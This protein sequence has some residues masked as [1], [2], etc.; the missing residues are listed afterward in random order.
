MK[1]QLEQKEIEFAR[2][3]RLP[4]PETLTVGEMI[5]LVTVVDRSSGVLGIHPV[6]FIQWSRRTDVL[7]KSLAFQEFMEW[8]DLDFHR[9]THI[10]AAHEFLA[11]LVD[12]LRKPSK[13]IRPMLLS[14]AVQ[15]I[16]Q[17]KDAPAVISEHHSGRVESM[18]RQKTDSRVDL[19]PIISA[20]RDVR[21]TLRHHAELVSAP[22][23]DVT[24]GLHR[25]SLAIGNAG[26]LFPTRNEDSEAVDFCNVVSTCM[27]RLTDDLLAAKTW[28]ADAVVGLEKAI[29]ALESLQA[30][31]EGKQEPK[32]SNPDARPRIDARL[33]SPSVANVDRVD[34]VIV[35][36]GF[37]DVAHP[38]LSGSSSKPKRKRHKPGESSLKILAAL[39]SLADEG[40]WN[41]PETDIWKRAGV[42]RSTYY[43]VLKRDEAVKNAMDEYHARRLGRGPVRPD[44]LWLMLSQSK[45][46]CPMRPMRYWTF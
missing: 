34:G 6:V 9:G 35:A 20:A 25:I 21:E 36:P 11:R 29:S 23:Y 31:R 43:D 3:E 5:E 1:Q 2:T 26:Q 7:N 28:D 37:A 41:A 19:T 4:N 18:P 14:D 42:S 8:K 17:R 10:E 22:G 16:K 38:H 32:Y 30:R 13:E 39:K 40:K 46:P 24:L 45:R 12:F 33:D 15:L 44:D 27:T